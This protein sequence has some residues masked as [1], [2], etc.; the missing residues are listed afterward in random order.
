[1]SYY[2]FR[3]QAGVPFQAAVQGR[4]IL[5]DEVDGAAG[6]DITPM[7][8]NSTLRTLPNRKKAFK[9][10]IDY[11]AIVLQA[12]TACTV[13]LFLSVTDVSLGFADGALVNVAGGVEILNG[14][15][16]RI[17]VDLA[18]GTVNVNASSVAN[19]ALNT[20]VNLAQVVVG[21]AAASVVNDNTLRR[22]RFRNSHA[23]ANIALGGAGVTMES[24]ILLGPGQSWIEEDAAGA[25]WYA[26]SDTAGATLAMQGLKQ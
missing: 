2:K 17:P 8:N 13:S 20:I 12:A 6:V 9:L 25:N 18:G 21:V 7:R 1:M 14:L 16:K 26:I 3:L 19:Q 23:T 15:D 24:P 22:L 10:W 5:V 4:M 11:D